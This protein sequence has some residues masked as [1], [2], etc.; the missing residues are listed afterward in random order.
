MPRGGRQAITGNLTR[1][2][3]SHPVHMIEVIN[4]PEHF[5]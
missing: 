4:K 2:E 1:L 5:T 3:R